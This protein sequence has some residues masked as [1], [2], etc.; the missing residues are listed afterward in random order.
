MILY[1]QIQELKNIV[2][3]RNN[4]L[5]EANE[6]SDKQVMQIRVILDRSEREHQREMN[7][8]IAKRDIITGMLSNSI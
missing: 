4:K 2:A 3:D 7:A 6:K 8:E 1:F 5:E